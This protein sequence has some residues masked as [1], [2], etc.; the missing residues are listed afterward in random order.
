M[1]DR[2]RVFFFRVD[3][4]EFHLYVIINKPTIPNHLKT[5]GLTERYNLKVGNMLAMYM[6]SVYSNLD[7]AL[8]FITFPYNRLARIN[9]HF[10]PSAFSSAGSLPFILICFSH[11]SVLPF[12]LKPL[13]TLL[14]EQMMPD[15]VPVCTSSIHTSI[16]CA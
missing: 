2:G 16:Q 11:F 4:K 6:S 3:S 10:S 13:S 7:A 9:P 14:A 5:N 15:K 12:L 8:S 1:T